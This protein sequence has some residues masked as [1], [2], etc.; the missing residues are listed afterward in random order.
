MREQEWIEHSAYLRDQ[1]DRDLAYDGYYSSSLAAPP[2]WP[3]HAQREPPAPQFA[4]PIPLTIHPRIGSLSSSATPCDSPLLSRAHQA[5]IDRWLMT[6]LGLAV[7]TIKK[8]VWGCE[9]LA[10]EQRRAA[11]IAYQDRKLRCSDSGSSVD[12]DSTLVEEEFGENDCIEKGSSPNPSPSLFPS[13]LDSGHCSS[14]INMLVQSAPNSD[15]DIAFSLDLDDASD[16]GH[17]SPLMH[18]DIEQI[19]VAIC[20]ATS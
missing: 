7:W 4:Q 12:S 9:L 5:H 2:R 15:P 13:I 19:E 16:F 20:S 18:I 10:S 14:Y 11:T 17:D 3:G 1:T 8:W 6:E